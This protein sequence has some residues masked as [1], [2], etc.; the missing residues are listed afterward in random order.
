MLS[1]TC[2]ER[3]RAGLEQSHHHRKVS[4]TEL[5]QRLEGQ[6]G[7]GTGG[8]ARVGG[9]RGKEM[10][11]SEQRMTSFGNSINEKSV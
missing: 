2:G 4:W 6:E 9:G 3:L 7:V 1:A 11:H 10:L 5:P 8:K